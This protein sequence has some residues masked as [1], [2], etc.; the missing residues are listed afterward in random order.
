VGATYGNISVKGT[1]R[2]ALL[3]W[4]KSK[5]IAAFVGSPEGDWIAFSDEATD[6]Q[7]IR[8]IQDIVRSL[9]Q[10]LAPVCIA[11]TVYDE[12]NLYLLA[13]KNGQLEAR[14]NSCP[15]MM[16]E[17]PGEQDMRP[18]IEDAPALVNLLDGA[19]SLE[20]LLLV[21]KTDGSADYVPPI[22]LHEELA[23]ALGLPKYSVGFGYNYT[24]A[25][26][27]DLAANQL[28]KTPAN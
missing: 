23:A 27:V 12:E 9:T 19:I 18:R 16:M 22:E 1:T 21:L 15:G 28:I 13:A 2:G 7:D 8:W 26:G 11:I 5:G 17:D 3:D 10:E 14:Y 24:I 4:L 25:D 6:G 20:E